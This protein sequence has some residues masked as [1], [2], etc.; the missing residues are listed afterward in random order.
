MVPPLSDLLEPI[1]SA[2][3][4]M[5]C[6]RAILDPAGGRFRQLADAVA[7][8]GTVGKIRR[9]ID[10]ARKKR[11]PVVYLTASRRSDRAGS[12]ANCPL[13]AAADD[14]EA[15]SPG[16]EGHAMVPG[17]EP[18]ANDFVVNRMHG[19]SP[20]HGTEL[21]SLLRNLGVRTVVAA[22]VSVNVGILG[23]V[24]EAVN[25]GYYVV[26][27]RDAVAG[28]PESYVEQVF[29]FTFRWLATISTVDEV[30]EHWLQIRP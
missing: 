19:V 26:L 18:T 2:L 8:N 9:L 30:V 12:S 22:G 20:F 29:K 17:L 14:G 28:V 4:V 13:L 7:Q 25:C 16:S 27:P 23:L 11:I 24:V 6:Q 5:E 3:L 21:D 1:H 10:A 15:M